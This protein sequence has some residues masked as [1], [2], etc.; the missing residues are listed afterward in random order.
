M[1]RQARNRPGHS[2]SKANNVMLH[3]AVMSSGFELAVVAAAPHKRF[4]ELSGFER[5]VEQAACALA[6]EVSG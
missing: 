2:T 5:C 3:G 6:A 4:T 1:T